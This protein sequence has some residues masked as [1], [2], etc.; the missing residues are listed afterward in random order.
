VGSEGILNRFLRVTSRKSLKLWAVVFLLSCGSA[1]ILIWIGSQPGLLDSTVHFKYLPPPGGLDQR[2]QLS[3]T[4]KIAEP[5][6]VEVRVFQTGPLEPIKLDYHRV[7]LAPPTQQR[8][9]YSPPS[10]IRPIKRGKS[11]LTLRNGV[12]D[13][14]PGKSILQIAGTVIAIIF[15]VPGFRRRGFSTPNNWALGHW[16]T[17]ETKVTKVSCCHRRESSP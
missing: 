16:Q 10:R 4:N 5:L 2:R 9:Y 17:N 14:Q 3:I 1:L 6:T 12:L 11:G 15:L 8:S 13:S 7:D